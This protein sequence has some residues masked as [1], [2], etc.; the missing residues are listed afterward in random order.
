MARTK[1]YHADEAAEILGISVD[2]VRIK[3]SNGELKGH[4]Q[5]GRW[6][7]DQAQPAFFSHN[8]DRILKEAR[9]KLGNWGPQAS[10]RRTPF[11]PE[12]TYVKDAEHEDMLYKA[13][14]STKKSL[15]IATA[16]FKYAHI[17]GQTLLEILEKIA[18]RGVHIRVI[19]MRPTDFVKEKIQASRVLRDTS[20][21]EYME[22]SRC[23][24][25]MF[26]FDEEKVY[27]GSA[28]LTNAAMGEKDEEERNFEVGILT[29]EPD[30]VNNAYDHFYGIW[31]EDV[32]STCTKNCEFN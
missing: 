18:R 22:C 16:N 23:H 27:L 29:T 1:Y 21:F 9:E 31:N 32:C 12:T 4:K 26:I 10:Q 28:N 19:C 13:M 15:C 24:M 5:R 17:K 8:L 7:V 25:K 2:N 14:M 6:L 11:V 20:K 3:L 30:I